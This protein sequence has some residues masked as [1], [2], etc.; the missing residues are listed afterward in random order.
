MIH[1]KGGD[2]ANFA[3]L[4]I[5]KVRKVEHP[6]KPTFAPPETLKIRDQMASAVTKPVL[7]SLYPTRR[8]HMDPLDKPFCE[9][10]AK[11]AS[12]LAGK[13]GGIVRQ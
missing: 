6:T 10:K 5:W 2:N 3:S 7:D 4:T 9:R 12:L 13:S 11:L 1:K 8:S